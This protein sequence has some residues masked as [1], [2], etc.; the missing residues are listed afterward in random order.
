[1][2]NVVCI[3]L[4]FFCF[5]VLML[6]EISIRR[7]CLIHMVSDEAAPDDLFLPGL[8]T[9]GAHF[10]EA[11]CTRLAGLGQKR[12]FVPGQS[13]IRFAPKAVIRAPPLPRV[14][15]H[16]PRQRGCLAV[17]QGNRWG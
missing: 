16:A 13:N 12:S 4:M 8:G 3:G 10:G 6:I 5:L 17:Q 9:L 1:M 11:L 7:P 14:V 15:K 2:G